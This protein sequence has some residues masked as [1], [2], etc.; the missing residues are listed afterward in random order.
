MTNRSS[1]IAAVLLVLCGTA[2]AQTPD[3][4]ACAALKQLQV[5]G[6][7]FAVTKTKWI[8]AGRSGRRRLRHR[9][10]HRAAAGLERT[11]SPSGWRRPQWL[12]PAAH[13]RE[14]G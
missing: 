2:L 12:G 10:R 13:G 6:V 4:A 14:C 7:N 5:P 1:E 11:F 3:A 9:L 8:P